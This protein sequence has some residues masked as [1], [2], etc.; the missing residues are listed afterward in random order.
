MPELAQKLPVLTAVVGQ[1]LTRIGPVGL[2]LAIRA[3]TF[4]IQ[5]VNVD[6]DA[7]KRLSRR[8]VRRPVSRERREHELGEH[9]RHG[10]QINDDACWRAKR[11]TPKINQPDFQIV[12]L[13]V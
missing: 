4:E 13:C 7:T 1:K 8:R 2:L 5:F 10:F 6:E 12:R 3:N 11:T 9:Q